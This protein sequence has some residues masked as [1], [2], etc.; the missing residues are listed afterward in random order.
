MRN[1]SSNKSPLKVSLSSELGSSVLDRNNKFNQ[2]VKELVPIRWV[3]DPQSTG[4]VTYFTSDDRDCTTLDKNIHLLN[5]WRILLP[6]R[7]KTESILI[8]EV[9][10]NLTNITRL[11]CEIKELGNIR[12]NKISRVKVGPLENG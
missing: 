7:V 11:N 6:L 2:K 3:G 10:I 5:L 4:L 8:L 12:C 9:Y 1:V